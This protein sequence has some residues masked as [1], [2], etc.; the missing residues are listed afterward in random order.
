MATSEPIAGFFADLPAG[1]LAVS[2]WTRVEFASL[3]AREVRIGAVWTPARRA[4]RV[5]GS[6]R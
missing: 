3:L 6:K 2:D 5:H 4:Q 1:D